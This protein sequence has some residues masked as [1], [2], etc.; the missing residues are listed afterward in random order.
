MLSRP[1]TFSV[2]RDVCGGRE[3]MAHNQALRLAGSL[4]QTR[5]SSMTPVILALIGIALVIGALLLRRWKVSLLGPVFRFEMLRSSRHVRAFSLRCAYALILLL[6][7]YLVYAS[8]FGWD[9]R[10]R[11]DVTRVF[12]SNG[13]ARFAGEFASTFLWVQLAAALVLTPILTAGAITEERGRRTFDCLLLTHLHD[14]EIVLGKLLARLSHVAL[15]LVAGLPLLGAVQLLG[16]VDPNL[17]LAAFAGTL[18]MMFSIG[19]VA[20]FNSVRSFNTI[21]AIVGTYFATGGYLYMSLCS[22]APIPWL[23]WLS[24]IGDGNPFVV[25]AR[26]FGNAGRSVAPLGLL[27][28][29]LRFVVFHAFAGTFFCVLATR[30]LRRGLDRPNQKLL[31]VLREEQKGRP[32]LAR[33]MAEPEVTRPPLWPANADNLLWWKERYHVGMRPWHGGQ[34]LAASTAI[35]MFALTALGTTLPFFIYMGSDRPIDQGIP[36]I[37][38][39]VA[40]TALSCIFLL[41]VAFSAAGTFS[42]ERTRR[43]LDSLLATPLES[44]TILRVKIFASVLGIRIGWIVLGWFWLAAL[45]S[46]GLHVLALPLLVAGWF[47]FAILAAEIGVL[48]SLASRNTLRATI[49]TL[50]ILAGIS[51]G[52]PLLG[53]AW[54]VFAPALGWPERSLFVAAITTYGASPPMILWG[55][56]YTGNVDSP[57][58]VHA[59]Y[60]FIAAF[61]GTCGHAVIAWLLWR[62]LVAQFG[63]LT[64]RMPVA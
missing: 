2:M 51:V 23:R 56:A 60:Q 35:T 63:R 43:T 8:W 41:P 50:A 22:M 3:S 42:R 62:R 16:G 7:L 61:I 33:R 29:T 46:G 32:N 47:L 6:I 28:S 44:Q 19:S 54:D 14:R 15:I 26:E 13:M 12:G 31:R 25:M 5:D 4:V 57:V 40:G 21:Q 37:W 10:S 38:A 59:R 1:S 11:N 17:V 34:I 55:L 9:G 64:G 18:A 30:Q 36:N 24:L 58:L 27:E 20:V 53:L 52:P 39:R 45:V 49:F 48:C